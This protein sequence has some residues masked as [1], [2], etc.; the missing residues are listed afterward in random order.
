[1][2]YACHI[3]GDRVSIKIKYYVDW[4]YEQSPLRAIYIDAVL[5]IIQH[6]CHDHLS[7]LIDLHWFA[8]V[9][10]CKGSC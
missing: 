7:D 4:M 3:K 1:M 2:P 9:A 10:Y 6:A 5:K 8:A